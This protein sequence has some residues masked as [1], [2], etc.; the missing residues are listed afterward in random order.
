MNI[1]GEIILEFRTVRQESKKLLA[2]KPRQ[3]TM[4]NR[5]F[6][7]MEETLGYLENL[8]P[9]YFKVDISFVDKISEVYLDRYRSKHC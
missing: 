2:M 8:N 6:N 3:H 7:L 9:T 5:E 1:S 4:R